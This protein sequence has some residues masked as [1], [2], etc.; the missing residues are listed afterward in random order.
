MIE[1]PVSALESRL[2]QRHQPE[3]IAPLITRVAF[4]LNPDNAT[5]KH[6]L[7]SLG[8]AAAGFA[9]KVDCARA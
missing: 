2:G 6:V 3:M 5:H 1:M 8:R 4:L 7:A 9:V